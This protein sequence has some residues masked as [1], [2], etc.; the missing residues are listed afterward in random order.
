[1]PC[2]VLVE[3]NIT[4]WDLPQSFLGIREQCFEGTH[5]AGVYECP[6]ASDTE[7]GPGPHHLFGK[8]VEP[9]HQGCQ[10]AVVHRGEGISCDQTRYPFD[11]IGRQR[12]GHRFSHKPALLV[13]FAGMKVQ[14]GQKVRLRRPQS[15]SQQIGEEVMLT[16]PVALVV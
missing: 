8:R 11:V 1:M 10:L 14:G 3:A 12:L 7:P 13:P 4:G 15:F 5:L 2:Y 9:R 16:I 6:G